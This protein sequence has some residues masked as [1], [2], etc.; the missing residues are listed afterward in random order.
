MSSTQPSAVNGSPGGVRRKRTRSAAAASP[1]KNAVD[2]NSK[3]T[4]YFERSPT[5]KT[6]ASQSSPCPTAAT[7][8][9]SI[10]ESPGVAIP[11]IESPGAAE[12]DDYAQIAAS[13][14]QISLLRQNTK[15]SPSTMSNDPFLTQEDS[16]SQERRKFETPSREGYKTPKER[17]RQK[18]REK[19][20]NIQD[21]LDYLEK[22][23]VSPAYYTSPTKRMQVVEELPESAKRLAIMRQAGTTCKDLFVFSVSHV[24]SNYYEVDLSSKKGSDSRWLLFMANKGMRQWFF[25]S[26]ATETMDLRMYPPYN[27][28]CAKW[29]RSE[30]AVE[31]DAW[32]REK[33]C[34]AWNRILRNDI[35]HGR[36]SEDR[37][38]AL[39]IAMMRDVGA[40]DKLFDRPGDYGDFVQ[41]VV[42]ELFTRGGI[43]S[44][45]L[46]TMPQGQGPIECI[47]RSITENYCYFLKKHFS[48]KAFYFALTVALVC[49]ADCLLSANGSLEPARA[50][51]ELVNCVPDDVWE[52]K[53]FNM[54]LS[55]SLE[56]SSDTLRRRLLDM[57]AS[58]QALNKSLRVMYWRQ[59]LA[60]A[61]LHGTNEGWPY[62]RLTA[63]GTIKTFILPFAEKHWKFSSKVQ[64]VA[65]REKLRFQFSFALHVIACNLERLTERE[66][67]GK[68]AAADSKV[69][70]RRALQLK[71][72][73]IQVRMGI[74]DG[75]DA[76]H[77]GMFESLHALT[78]FLAECLDFERL[79]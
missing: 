45:D 41:D 39:T 62:G 10:G 1:S 48:V 29:I 15:G 71:L 7:P 55:L 30:I 26:E 38:R 67:G 72:D 8:L 19:E 25:A 13:A 54:A 50:V 42:P 56:F 24:R 60:L 75:S 52:S 18:Q 5:K 16:K 49:S 76:A 73:D 63:E 11:S 69:N 65:R 4:A 74:P 53:V 77:W 31:A 35:D 40:N 6:R 27:D 22:Q 66:V 51:S 32:M 43:R 9:E 2:N 79:S 37:L 14:S 68:S 64:V 70:A 23:F 78:L 34:K 21:A 28:I 57:L 44:H 36:I 33:Y 47:V 20:Q 3:I 46:L 61:S 12:E 17:Q 58:V 59:A